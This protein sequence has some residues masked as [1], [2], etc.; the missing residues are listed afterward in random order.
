MKDAA[1]SFRVARADEGPILAELI[2]AA[3]EGLAFHTW[4]KD[5]G[6]GEDPWV[7]G[8]ER[9]AA[10]AAEGKWVVA[11]EGD[12]P[13]AGLRGEMLPDQ[14]EPIPD[15]F[16][17]LFRPLQELEDA[18]AGSFYVHVL[19]CR[20]GR[21]GQGWGTLLLSLA[22]DI[23]RGMSC[24]TLSIIVADSNKGARRLYERFGFRETERRAMVKG[25][26]QSDG[27]EWVL[28]LKPIRPC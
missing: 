12:E 17:P 14:P 13:V 8:A 26:W 4:S 18:A 20:E 11:V 6:P 27:A 7:R 25:D 3:S 2:E 19:A 1:S 15:D 24:K 9:Q 5:A 16:E 23:A 21:R 10:A 28:M 22:E